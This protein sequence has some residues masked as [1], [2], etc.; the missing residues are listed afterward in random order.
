MHIKGILFDFDGVVVK[1]MEQHFNAWQKAFAERGV[2][3][4][5]DEFFIM[6]GQ[7]IDTISQKIGSDHS[8]S[9]ADVQWVK[10]RKV[11]FY[12]QFMTLEYYDYFPTLLKNLQHRDVPMG[13][14]TGGTRERVGG[15]VEKHFQGVFSCVVT[16]DDV[17]RGKPFPDPF[18]SGAEKLNLAPT[19]CLVVE[20]APLGI[21]GAKAAGMTVIGITTTLA[22]HYLNQADYILD[23]FNTVEKQIMKLLNL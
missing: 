10:E 7:G 17:E 8:L 4:S 5:P 12:N 11:N 1:S 18:L 21:Q 9:A 2:H 16:V 20:N 13:I 19:E 14:V 3:I 6:E 15:I 23:D 22:T